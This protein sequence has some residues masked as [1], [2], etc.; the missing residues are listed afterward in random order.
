M[1]LRI[2]EKNTRKTRVL[3]TLMVNVRVHT[4]NDMVWRNLSTVQHLNCN[5]FTNFFLYEEPVRK[6]CSLMK[7]GIL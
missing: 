1:G 6:K 7:L 5:Y 3:S 4:Q 2:F